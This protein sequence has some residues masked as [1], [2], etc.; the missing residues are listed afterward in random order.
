MDVIQ[1]S[2]LALGQR[3][4]S[5]LLK[6]HIAGEFTALEIADQIQHAARELR[7][8]LNGEDS[9]MIRHG[10]AIEEATKEKCFIIDSDFFT[11]RRLEPNYALRLL[12]NFNR[13]SGCLFR[14]CIQDA[15]HD[16]M[17]PQPVG[18]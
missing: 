15:L 16:A 14:W 5:E 13:E 12:D 9:V 17:G 2:K 1:R 4:W 8:Q 18:N 11:E 6:P 3:S 10:I 7:V